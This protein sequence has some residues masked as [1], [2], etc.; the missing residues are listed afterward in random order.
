VSEKLLEIAGPSPLFRPSTRSSSDSPIGLKAREELNPRTNREVEK[1]SGQASQ[2]V[3]AAP[4]R[5]GAK[6]TPPWRRPGEEEQNSFVCLSESKTKR[7]V[8]CL[9]RYAAGRSPV[10]ARFNLRAR[11]ESSKSCWVITTGFEKLK[12]PA[13]A[14]QGQFIL[15]QVVSLEGA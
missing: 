1:W 12:E 14:S 3:N 5:V 7:K 10:V 11:L 2:R 6:S 4:G 15:G 9:S 13:A 8:Y